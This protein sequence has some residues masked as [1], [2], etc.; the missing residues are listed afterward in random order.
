MASRK[1]SDQRRGAGRG[2]LG[3]TAAA[4]CAGWLV[5]TVGSNH[6]L[7][8][9]DRLR[10]HD[11]H[12]LLIPNWRFF[13]PEPAQHDLH[14]LHRVLSADGAQTPWRLTSR[15]APRAWSHVMWHAQR[16]REKALFDIF[17]QLAMAKD[18]GRRDVSRTA[19]YRLLRDFVEHAVRHEHAGG[20]MPRGFQF[21]VARDTGHDEQQEPTYL[22]VSEFCRLEGGSA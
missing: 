13:A 4:A 7:T 16:R 5:V 21:V 2:F 11:R 22:L 3:W 9:F 14:V 12:G 1:P 19:A 6:P 15:Y 18:A 20:A 10:R 17:V 8:Q